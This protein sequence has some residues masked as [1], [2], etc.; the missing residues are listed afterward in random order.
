[1]DLAADFHRPAGRY[2]LSHSVGLRPK[3]ADEIVRSRF[4]EPW[5]R[6]EA[7]L[8]DVWLA[9]I[10][11]WRAAL[12]GF[13]NA[14]PEDLCPQTNI[15]SALT[16]ILF[17]L[18]ARRGR[19]RIVLCEDD[20][21]T[22]GFVAEQARR[23]GYSVEFVPGGPALADPDAWSRLAGDDVQLALATH[24]FS[25]SALVAP[26]AEIV[27]RARERGVFVVLD[28]AQSAG[29][30]PLDLGAIRPDFAVGTSIKYLCGGP[31]AAF[32]YADS[33]AAARASPVD[34]GWFSHENPFEF[35]IRRFRYAA[36]ALRFWGGTPSV[37][38]YATALA[39]LGALSSVGSAA[40]A[41][42]NERLIGRLIEALEPH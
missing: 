9:V 25:N 17:S 36:G 28:L 23:S 4:S 40:I 42:H 8:W 10:D 5:A 35:D 30:V 34:V 21:P 24:V 33:E 1:M 7:G 41:A 32:L 2:F 3:A 13:L 12:G 29:A 16:K 22:V 38:P 26:V 6:G 18:P 14:S 27:R 31:G 39:G 19:N 20:F 11:D 15:S 37:A